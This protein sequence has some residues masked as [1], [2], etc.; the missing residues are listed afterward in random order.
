M[1]S[2]IQRNETKN[3]SFNIKDPSTERFQLQMPVLHQSKCMSK[4][5]PTSLGQECGQN[6]KIKYLMCQIPIEILE[7]HVIPISNYQI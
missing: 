4:V 5:G 2:K 1:Y 7:H 6:I 3:G